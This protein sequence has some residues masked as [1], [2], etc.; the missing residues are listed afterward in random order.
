MG[1]VENKEK[2]SISFVLGI[3]LLHENNIIKPKMVIRDLN[4]PPDIV[5]NQLKSL[6]KM[7]EEENYPNFKNSLTKIGMKPE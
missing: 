5:V 3:K 4:M 7:L 1:R 6:I 2:E